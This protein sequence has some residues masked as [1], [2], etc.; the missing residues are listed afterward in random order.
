MSM[1]YLDVRIVQMPGVVQKRQEQIEE[2]F[3]V[4]FAAHVAAQKFGLGFQQPGAEPF[5][6]H[7]RAGL[8]EEPGAI[9]EGV[10]VLGAQRAVAGAPDVTEHHVGADGCC[11][12]DQIVLGAIGDGAAAQQHLA[13]LIESQSPAQGF[14]IGPASPQNSAVRLQHPR[15]K[16]CAVPDKAEHACHGWSGLGG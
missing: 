8:R 5:E 2:A 9:T 1:S 15:A 7:D 10:R 3:A 13:G 11:G 4:G 16:I 12:L 6:T 14:A